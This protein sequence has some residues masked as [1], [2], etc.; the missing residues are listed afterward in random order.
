MNKDIKLIAED[1]EN[2]INRKTRSIENTNNEW[3][4]KY[5]DLVERIKEYLDR[6]KEVYEAF[7]EDGLSLN[8]VEGEG[9]YRGLLTAYNLA[10]EPIE[11][12]KDV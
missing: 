10:K 4:E 11:G 1:I 6:A 2:L 8:T 12:E 3:K 7:K 9:Y 5:S